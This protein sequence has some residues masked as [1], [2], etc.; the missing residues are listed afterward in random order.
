MTMSWEHVYVLAHTERRVMENS[1]VSSIA[2]VC[3]GKAS[4]KMVTLETSS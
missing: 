1:P 4:E 2:R 3:K